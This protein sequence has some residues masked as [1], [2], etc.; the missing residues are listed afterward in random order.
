MEQLGRRATEQE[1]QE[2]SLPRCIRAAEQHKPVSCIRNYQIE[3]HGFGEGRLPIPGIIIKD[4]VRG[5]RTLQSPSAPGR[6]PHT[7]LTCCAHTDCSASAAAGG[8]QQ[9]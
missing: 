1:P 4:K 2:L 6:G 5:S 7:A 9:Q 8:C 3:R